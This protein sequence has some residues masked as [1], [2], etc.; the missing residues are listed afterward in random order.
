MRSVIGGAVQIGRANSLHGV[1]VPPWRVLAAAK[2]QVLEQMREPGLSRLFVLRPHVV[3]DVDGHNRRLVIL[4]HDHGQTVV[5][6]EALIGNI[7]LFCLG[8]GGLDA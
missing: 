5:E 8:E 1:D 3:P 7:N 6:H 2:H 4:M